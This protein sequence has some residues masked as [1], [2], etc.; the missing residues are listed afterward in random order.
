[1]HLGRNNPQHSYTMEKE[2]EITVSAIENTREEEDLGVIFDDELR[3][4]A[5][6][7]EKVK[8]KPTRF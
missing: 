7:Q 6:I 5:H 1:M 4:T 3:F 8:K 2:V